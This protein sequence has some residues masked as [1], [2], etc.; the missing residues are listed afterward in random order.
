MKEFE[1]FFDSMYLIFVIFIG[2]RLLLLRKENTGL[3]GAMA[4]LQG[5]GDA[6]HLIPRIV[7]NV[8]VNGF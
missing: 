1:L 3:V 7:A 2:I 4:M 5:L 8:Q 6:F